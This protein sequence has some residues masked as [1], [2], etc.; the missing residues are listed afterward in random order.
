MKVLLLTL[1][2]I[3]LPV[4]G[5][6]NHHEH[7]H[8]SSAHRK[9]IEGKD[10]SAVLE[11]LAKNELLFNAFLKK[12]SALI[13]K[14]AK[15]LQ[16]YIGRT[17]A[18]LLKNVKLNISKLSSIKSSNTNEDNLK[19]YEAFLNP[20]IKVVREYD[21]GRKYNVFSCPMVKKSWLQNTDLNK[22]V[23][24]IYAIDMLECGSQDTAF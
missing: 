1:L 5:Q 10:K 18:P 21:V 20:L 7:G 8:H 12:D 6:H 3:S 9:P 19:A 13:E 23:K 14:H 24:N 2:A 4:L 22:E 15:E 11:V 17:H 16:G